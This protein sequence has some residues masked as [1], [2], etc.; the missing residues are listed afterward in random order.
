MTIKAETFW[1]ANRAKFLKIDEFRIG[2]IG[3]KQEHFNHYTPQKQDYSSKQLP[4][5]SV[6]KGPNWLTKKFVDHE[7]ATKKVVDQKGKKVIDK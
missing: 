7:W 1:H 3:G 4:P 2:E 5:L 6:I